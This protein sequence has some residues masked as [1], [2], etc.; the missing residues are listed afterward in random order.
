MRW[1]ALLKGVNVGGNRTLP[2][3]ELKRFVEGLGHCDVRTLLASGNVVFGADEQDPARLEARLAAEAKAM[4]GIDT[5]WLVRSHADLAAIVAANPF[6]DAATAHPNHLLVTFHRD[7]LPAAL[8]DEA[9]AVHDGPER[10]AASG[11]ELFVD[12]PHGIGRSALH[13]VIAKL[14]FPKIATARNWNTVTKLAALTA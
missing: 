4:I 13:R 12:Y 9:V 5:D 14:R 6:P 2:M 11:R 10:L 7:P 3:T 1:A 8:I